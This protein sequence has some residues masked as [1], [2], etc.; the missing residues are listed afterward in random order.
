MQINQTL[1]NSTIEKNDD[2]TGQQGYAIRFSNKSWKQ[3]NLTVEESK[4]LELVLRFMNEGIGKADLRVFDELIA[5]D[6]QIFTGLK[7]QGAIEGCEEYKSIY[8]PFA[9]AWPLLEFTIEEAFATDDKVVI[10]FEAIAYFNKDYYGIKATN[11]IVNMKEVHVVTV[12]DG[13]I[14]SNVVSGTN[15]PFE[16]IMYPVLK[17]GVIGNLPKFNI[18]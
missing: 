9:D 4:N 1:S 10:R 12:K 6:A 7:A 3:T 5:E 11:E 18:K 8:A 15:F 14:I 17:D 13:K 2:S 16:F